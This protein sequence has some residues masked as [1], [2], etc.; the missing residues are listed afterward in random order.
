MFGPKTATT[1]TIISQHKVDHEVLEPLEYWLEE[2]AVEHFEFQK[3]FDDLAER[4]LLVL[5]TSGTT[6]LP[7]PVNITHGLVGIVDKLQDLSPVDDKDVWIKRLK[8]KRVFC[9]LP[10][11]HVSVYTNEYSAFLT[12]HH[13]LQELTFS[14][15][16]YFSGLCLS[17][18]LHLSHQI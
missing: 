1:E 15:S 2:I 7:K 9:C 8:D 13:S 16:R 3:S 18:P 10:P 14:Y 12:N 6:G 11:F 4:P 17:Y 5:H